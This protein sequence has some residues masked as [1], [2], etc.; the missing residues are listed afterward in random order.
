VTP[1][2]LKKMLMAEARRQGKPYGLIIKDI[3]GGNTNTMS[4]GYQAFKGTPR[5]VYRVDAKTGKEELVRGVELIGTPLTSINKIVAT[6][7]L[8]PVFG[9]YLEDKTQRYPYDPEMARALLYDAGYANGFDLTFFVPESGSG[10]QSPVEMGTVIQAN[11]AAVGVRAKIQTMEWGAYLKKYLDN[12]DMAEMSWN[13]SIGD[14]DHMLYML[15]SSDR[16]PPAFN[17]GF[18]QNP[19][20]DELLRKGRT[21]IDDKER[22]PLYKEAQRLVMEDAPWIFVDHGKQVIVHR[23]RVQGFKLHPNFDLVLTQVW[24]Q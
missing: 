1:A 10:M 20:V 11:L 6:S 8:S 19:R 23:K 22:I 7:P 4:Y 3:T 21:T 17:A 2:E 12:P 14:P 5:L 9:A 13:P 24:L 18:Y 15:L 16:F